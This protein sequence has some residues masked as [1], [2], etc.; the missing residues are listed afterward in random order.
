MT[1]TFRHT[2]TILDTILADLGRSTDVRALLSRQWELARTEMADSNAHG[3][4][5]DAQPAAVN[6][7]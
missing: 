6:Q 7:R 2:R 4:P 3:D 1:T 5:L